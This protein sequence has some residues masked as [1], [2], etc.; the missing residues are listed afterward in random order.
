MNLW[1]SDQQTLRFTDWANS[2]LYKE[3][4]LAVLFEVCVVNSN[5]KKVWTGA[6]TSDLPINRHWPL[7]TELT[8][9]STSNLVRQSYL[10]S[11]LWIL[12]GKK[13]GLGF[14]SSLYKELRLSSNL[15]G[16]SRFLLCLSPV[17]RLNF[18][19]KRTK[20]IKWFISNVV[21]LFER[22]IYWTEL[23]KEILVANW[24]NC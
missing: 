24:K 20:V 14:Y 18:P 4:R 3:L 2:S 1:P 21:I 9:L 12:I 15:W 23:C 16:F 6:W 5:W 19:P 7:L 11:V 8:V 17:F 10:K 22:S 13:A